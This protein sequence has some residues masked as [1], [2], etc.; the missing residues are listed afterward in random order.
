MC[1][2][3]LDLSSV[4]FAVHA[5]LILSVVSKEFRYCLS[6]FYFV[7]SLL[8]LDWILKKT[9]KPPNKKNKSAHLFS[10]SLVFLYIFLVKFYFYF[11]LQVGVCLSLGMHVNAGATEARGTTGAGVPGHCEPH[12]VG[13]CQEPLSH[14]AELPWTLWTVKIQ[15]TGWW[16][17]N[18]VCHQDWQPEIDVLGSTW[19]K[20]EPTPIPLHVCHGTHVLN[21]HTDVHMCTHKLKRAKIQL[22]MFT[23][24][25]LKT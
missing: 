16:D 13:R 11:K 25:Y 1:L 8:L 12:D 4:I 23:H 7:S 24:V 10:L 3:F 21:M 14:L 5:D 15:S 22:N 17:G 9:Q 2:G 18:G 20:K 19:A 6:L